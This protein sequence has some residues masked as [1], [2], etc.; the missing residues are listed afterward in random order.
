MQRQCWLLKSV[1][2]ETPPPFVDRAARSSFVT[3]TLRPPPT[4]YEICIPTC[5]TSCCSE[6]DREKTTLERQEKKLMGDIK[7]TAKEGQMVP[8]FLRS[9]HAHAHAHAHA[10]PAFGPWSN[11]KKCHGCLHQFARLVSLD[12]LPRGVLAQLPSAGRPIPAQQ[13]HRATC[14]P[15]ASPP[16]NAGASTPPLAIS[17]RAQIPAAGLAGRYGQT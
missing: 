17:P 11:A 2:G 1:E 10:H 7:K 14:Y 16:S 13:L 15:R 6:L 9:P 3:L 8:S 5:Q 4:S 12:M